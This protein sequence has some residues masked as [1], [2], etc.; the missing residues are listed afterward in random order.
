MGHDRAP[1]PGMLAALQDDKPGQLQ[2]KM[3][4]SKKSRRHRSMDND[5]SFSR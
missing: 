3:A 1:D 5:G 4:G 2:S